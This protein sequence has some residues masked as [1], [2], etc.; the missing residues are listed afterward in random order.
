[1]VDFKKRLR[2]TGLSKPLDP[3]VIYESLDR[4]S[5]KGPLRPV[6]TYVLGK[7]HESLRSPRDVIVKL[8]T[9][10]G[11]TLIGLLMLHSRL[12][13]GK[14]PA[15]YFCPNKYLVEQTCN[16]AKQFGIPFTTAQDALP[17]AFLDGTA[18]LIAPVQKLFNGLTKFGLGPTSVKLGTIVLDDSH[19]CV[20][21]IKQA[22]SITLGSTSEAYKEIIQLFDADLQDQGI[23]SFADIKRGSNDVILPV[24]YW[25]WAD[26]S[27]EIASIIAKHQDLNEIKFTWPLLRDSID[28]CLC[29][30]SGHALEIVPYAPPLHLFGSYDNATHRVF[31]SATVTDD[32]FLVK[33]LGL[34]PE[35]ISQPLVYPDEK[36]CGEKMVLIP[37]LIHEELDRSKI[38]SEFAKPNEKRKHGVVA[39]CPSF[40]ACEDWRKYGSTVAEK[41]TITNHLKALRA[42]AFSKTLVIVNRYDGIDLPDD[43]C[44]ILLLDSTPYADSLID[45]Y[46]ESCRS[47]SEAISVR[48]ARIIEQGLG[49]S[50]RGEKD[51][52]V[53]ILTGANLVQEIRSKNARRFYSP[54]T[55]AQ[56]EIGLELAELAKEDIT[57]GESPEKAFVSLARKCLDRDVGWKEFY[58][59]RMNEVE[60]SKADATLLEVFA[61]EREAERHFEEGN[62]DGAAATIQQL[63]DKYVKEPTEKGWYLQEMARYTYRHSKTDSNKLQI[64][65]H[66]M[67]LFLLKPKSGMVVD[68]LKPLS[69]R[70][71]EGIA[72]W[73]TQFDD[74]EA[75]RIKLDEILDNLEFGVLPDSFE[76]ALNE[77]GAALGFRTQRPDKEWKA[78]PDN[79]WALRD[80]DYL[81]FECKNNVDVR[82]A[83]IAKTESGQM[84]N[85]CAWFKDNYGHSD[86]RR[87]LIFPARKLGLGAG[88]NEEVHVM[89]QKG[90]RSL[91]SN[92]RG[93]FNEMR[94]LDLR[95][96]DRDAIQGWLETHKLDTDAIK[97]E[98]TETVIR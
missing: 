50:V 81:L 48:T 68:K 98:Y 11:K 60:S 47:K 18:I 75:L 28:K 30:V 95:D 39:L 88:F 20:D 10:Q 17:D 42:G 89:R 74:F 41:A 49:R 70:R 72:A 4:A 87:V 36:W 37:S 90:L 33:G 77:L 78:G 40:R 22:S 53:I 64:S 54:Q 55:R 93:F 16:E 83:E 91:R 76:Q 27:A 29:V 9:G 69:Q 14:G 63:I 44:R 46:A 25:A 80:D 97:A 84:N 82:R 3:A 67:N 94:R 96:I 35:T 7:W 26:R 32:S 19:A 6:Q 59:E 79:L 31:M 2:K 71:V 58:S 34:A 5:D 12:N 15:A 66:R 65:A 21:A 43:S 13:E 45:R 73:V 92:A 51:Y 24:P 62:C 56:L 86:V 52:C 8:H 1:M 57:D 61:L 85:A 38:V 23:G